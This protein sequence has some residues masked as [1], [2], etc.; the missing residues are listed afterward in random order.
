MA[1]LAGVAYFNHLPSFPDTGK[2]PNQPDSMNSLLHAF[3]LT[4][5][6]ARI[7]FWIYGTNLLLSLL[8]L[9]PAY[10]TLGS[11]MGRSMAFTNLLDGFDY[12]VFS[13]FMKN[14]GD[15]VNG[16]LATGRW[17]GI[18]WLILSVFLS[19]GILLR[20]SQPDQ[21]V[22]AS[23]FLA[24]CAQY[25]GR[26]AGLLGVISLFFVV[27]FVVISLIGT[28]IGAA[29]YNSVTEQILLYIGVATVVIALLISALVFCIGDYAKVMLFRQDDH[30][31]FRAFGRAGRLVLANL[32]LTFGPYLLLIAAG[33]AL[34]GLYFLI[35]DLI[36][37]R[38]W[39]TII[40]L[41]LIQQA[42][43]AARI[44]L[45]VWSL[46]T[47]YTISNTLIKPT[48]PRSIVITNPFTTPV[49]PITPD[50]RPAAE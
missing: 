17:L 2:R 16:L 44:F 45:K 26:Y 5:R 40:I 42:F 30:N 24:G 10:A 6:S 13:D 20:F 12:T 23:A 27:L 25:V 48:P 43:I 22:R 34:F 19:G 21:P 18:L 29:L 50:I 41:F 46:G 4:R 11:G 47:A 14:S 28:L 8:I 39:P 33:T 38:N 3:S 35:D 7:V 31:A 1:G 32:G 15:A 9:L 49:E 36:G 37:M